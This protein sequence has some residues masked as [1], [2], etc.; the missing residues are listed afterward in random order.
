MIIR[1]IFTIVDA[2]HSLRPGRTWSIIND[3]IYEN[4]R[5]KESNET[6]PTKTEIEDEIKKL[7]KQYDDTFYQ[8]QRKEEY[9][10]VEM[11][12][13]AVVKNDKD[14]IQEYID[15]CL[16]VKNKYPKPE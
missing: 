11:Y 4:L 6:K 14:A 10:P 8:L 1:K 15:A 2:L 16:A 3:E 12:L 7:Q 9:P 5:W 13:D